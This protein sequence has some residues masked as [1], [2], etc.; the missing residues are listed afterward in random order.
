MDET[1]SIPLYKPAFDIG[2]T[3]YVPQLD[4]PEEAKVVAY[5]VRVMNVDGELKAGVL[6][7]LIDA[8]CLL[9][10]GD[11]ADLT[12]HLTRIELF[13]DLEAATI[14]SKPYRIT[15]DEETWRQAIGE[16]DADEDSPYHHSNADLA[17]CCP[18]ISNIRDLLMFAREVGGLVGY[19][20][21]ALYQAL[22]EHGINLQPERSLSSILRQLDIHPK[23][24]S[25]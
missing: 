9:P 13:A 10:R 22:K 21:D 23:D 3:V 20:R 14:A 19:Q 24:L 25:A 11:S 7:Y 15:A 2:Q 8:F 16:R 5:N 4:G 6:E 18:N 17:P 1:I 12:T